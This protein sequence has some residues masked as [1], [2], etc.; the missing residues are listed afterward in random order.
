MHIN[1]SDTN[2]ITSDGRFF[3][4]IKFGGEDIFVNSSTLK[5][6]TIVQ[7]LCYFLPMF[8]L[9]IKDNTGDLTH[10]IPFDRGMS[11]VYIE[12]AKDFQ[13]EDRNSWDFMV[14]KRIP[15]SDQSQPYGI[16]TIKGLL[17]LD[18]IFSP[19]YSRGFNQSIF[20]TLESIA[21]EFGVDKTEISS[22]LAYTKNLLQP[23]WYNLQFLNYLTENLIGKNGESAYRTFIK[24]LNQKST[25][26]F[27]SLDELILSPVKFK[28]I[29]RD[30]LYE[31]R[32]PIY[33]YSIIDN[34]KV[35]ST[36][37]SKTQNYSY[38]NYSSGTF[39][40]GS[41]EAT[42]FVSTTD[43][44]L[45]DQNDTTDSI[46]LEET[47]RSTDFTSNFQ[48]KVKT[49][50][51]NKLNDLVK[52]WITTQGIPNIC[53]GDTVEIFFPQGAIADKLYS[54]Q[55]S[56]YWLVERTVHMVG[57]TFLTRL[58]LTR[59]GVDTDISNTLMRSTTKKKD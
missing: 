9:S 35:Y 26:V 11:K 44:F 28:F 34:Y 50:T 32:Y 3:L 22:S 27:K 6:L 48:G 53:P 33:N 45:I 4:N 40:T 36:F 41:V 17:N 39:V 55:Y 43:F 57:D 59:T 30:T 29:L 37:S 8:T 12:L 38:Y 20:T 47:G 54:Y 31:D 2:K 13:S 7:D 15:S 42:D 10:T 24:C 56:G 14:H 51:Y 58:L 1:N 46:A 19:S 52:I 21:K 25:F 49:D 18:K 5:E 16:Y 23:N